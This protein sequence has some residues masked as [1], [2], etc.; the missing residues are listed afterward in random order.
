EVGISGWGPSILK[1]REYQIAVAQTATLDDLNRAIAKV[2]N[3]RRAYPT[4]RNGDAV[5]AEYL[6]SLKVKRFGLTRS[7]EHRE[8]AIGAVVKAFLMDE[9]RLRPHADFFPDLDRNIATDNTMAKLS[10][11]I[12]ERL[13]TILENIEKRREMDRLLRTRN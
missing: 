4:W 7:L 2:R 12:G 9:I 1:V 6:A 11:D 5:A 3:W 8:K 10:Y 13:V